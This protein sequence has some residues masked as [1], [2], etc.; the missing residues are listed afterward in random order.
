MGQN[1]GK[2]IIYLEKANDDAISFCKCG[3][4][5]ISYPPQA[6]C[7]WCGC[8]WLFTCVSCR[9]AFTFARGV[10]LDC[11]YEELARKDLKIMLNR[12]PNEDEIEEWVEE[13]TKVLSVVKVG[14]TYVILD[15]NIIDVTDTDIDFEG[16]YAKHKF[17]QLPQVRAIENMEVIHE[18]LTQE[19]YWRNNKVKHQD[20]YGIE[21]LRKSSK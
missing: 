9:K 20:R 8:G 3:D 14:Q 11:T 4:G 2:K 13:I 16:W 15:G 7:P 6:D 19:E 21:L 17:E 10:E 12:E 1:Q 18:H 5:R